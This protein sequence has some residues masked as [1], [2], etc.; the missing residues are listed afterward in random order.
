VPKRTTICKTLSAIGKADDVQINDAIQHCPDNQVV[1]LNP[2]NYEITNAI[3]WRKSHVVLRGSGGPG[4]SP[5]HQTRLLAHP[6]LYG[7]VVN[8]GPDLFPHPTGPS[9]N[10]S[11][12]ALQGSKS[13]KV[14]SVSAFKV[15]DLVQIDITGDAANDTGKWLLDA[16]NGK[17]SLKYP[18]AE[19]DPQKMPKGNESRTWFSRQ[20]RPISQVL[21]VKS[22]DGDRLN[23]STPFHQTFDVAHAAQV[24]AFRYNGE[25][26]TPLDNAGL[27][28]LYVAGV[29]APGGKA[30]NNNIVFMLAKNSWVRNVES[31]QSLGTSIGFNSSLHC[32]ARDSYMHST[33]NPTPG[34]AGYGLAFS[35]AAAD[36]LAEN[37]IS[38]NFNKIMVM[39]ASGGG[40][41][42]S[43]SYMDDGYIAFQPNWVETGLNAAHMTTAHFELFE[44]NLSFTLG[45]ES[46]WGN[47]TFITWLRNLGTGHRSA[48]PPL[49]RFVFDTK[50]NQP[51]GCV[52]TGPGDQKCIPYTDKAPRAAAVVSFGHVFYNFLGNVL[53][54]RDIAQAP[55]T[56]GF[57][58]QS[59]GPDWATDPVPMWI[60]GFHVNSTETDRNVVATTFRDANF[61]Y[62]TKTVQPAN[63]RPVPASLY[64]CQKPDFF[65]GYAW[66]WVDGSNATAPYQTHPYRFHALSPSLGTFETSGELSSYSGFALPAFVR[67]LQL[68]GVEPTEPA[69]KSTAPADAPASCTLL[70]TGMAR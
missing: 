11:E 44:G 69:C 22:I 42:V 56:R 65:G 12:D 18:Y 4:A 34:G 57:A 9:V 20:D 21:E 16:P 47:A 40:N 27:E 38:W 17:T 33:V 48:W 50:A 8:I 28:D 30:Q 26:S 67:F 41:V 14:N 32:T 5:A 37:N 15:G 49:N 1:Q 51:G 59:E 7:P 39:R 25:N 13:V 24:T 3:L 62:A 58:Y 6:A 68:S 43:Y 29:P 36:N 64:L 55:Q 53:G 45:S 66:P 31:D 23:F 63:S 10:V 2:G 46:T 70:L 52:S 54:S 60:L 61:D 19:Y 35:L